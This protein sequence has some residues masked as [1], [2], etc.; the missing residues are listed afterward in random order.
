MQCSFANGICRAHERW[1]WTLGTQPLLAAAILTV[2]SD[3]DL[4]DIR[5]GNLIG[6]FALIFA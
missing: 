1:R 2:H 5:R 3:L 6:S 4:F